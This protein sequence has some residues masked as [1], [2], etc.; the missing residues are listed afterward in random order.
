MVL[1]ARQALQ[2]HFASKQRED[3]DGEGIV[4]GSKVAVLGGRHFPLFSAGDQGEVVRLDQEALNCDVLFEGARQSVPVALR[5]LRLVQLPLDSKHQVSDGIENSAR[6]QSTSCSATC[7]V[8]STAYSNQR[9]SLRGC[10]PAGWEE[11][12]PQ[13]VRGA[14]RS[15]GGG[16]PGS[17]A[18]S[19]MTDLA[20][21]QMG[22]GESPAS[23]GGSVTIS[24]SDTL[25][26]QPTSEEGP[27]ASASSAPSKRVSKNMTNQAD[28]LAPE[29]GACAE[30]FTFSGS[31]T[32]NGFGNAAAVSAALVAAVADADGRL[33][34]VEKLEAHIRQLLER[35]HAETNRL[36]SQLEKATT[37]GR[38]QQERVAALEQHIRN[39]QSTEP[40]T[41]TVSMVLRPTSAVAS[42]IPVPT[43]AQVASLLT[44]SSSMLLTA[45]EG[46]NSGAG[47]P[48]HSCCDPSGSFG[49]STPRRTAKM[50]ASS[51]SSGAVAPRPASVRLHLSATPSQA[52]DGASV[53][54]RLANSPSNCTVSRSSLTPP[55]PS[56]RL[57][58]PVEHV[59]S[60]LPSCGI[61]PG[62]SSRRALS[63]SAT[64]TRWTCQSVPAHTTAASQ[65]ALFLIARPN[66][67]QLQQQQQQ[68]Q[69]QQH[70]QQQPY[71]PTGSS[72]AATPLAFAPGCRPG[73]WWQQLQEE[74]HTQVTCATSSG[75]TLSPSR[76]GAGANTSMLT[77]PAAPTQFIAPGVAP[78]PP[79]GSAGCVHA[80]A[81]ATGIMLAP[82]NHSPV[83]LSATAAATALAAAAT[84][85][86]GAV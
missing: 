8:G 9:N 5:H 68:Q 11:G 12:C 76:S 61:S 80:P 74:T 29:G 45:T 64:P 84:P 32:F 75:V 20:S 13:G 34:R 33:V 38:Q 18:S 35:H 59:A 51:A 48:A 25:A 52:V 55:H 27:E 67:E 39:M 63:A 57:R 77:A 41:S 78:V 73:A 3:A 36:K 49:S 83:A 60:G 1:L 7:S 31:N 56:P 42:T 66:G 70:Q 17:T 69:Q 72:T 23:K 86:F 54:P 46:N 28:R 14:L 65:P 58:V 30:V 10:E 15:A 71:T 4:L 22:F 47:T 62:G 79:V 37:F 26:W 6:V 44:L 81:S 53:S 24:V 82:T 21:S 50:L 43:T 2:E 16:A 40:T 19:S 85:T